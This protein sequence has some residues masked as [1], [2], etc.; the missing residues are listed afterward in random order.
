VLGESLGSSTQDGQGGADAQIL[1]KT[2]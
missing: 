2:L 1:L